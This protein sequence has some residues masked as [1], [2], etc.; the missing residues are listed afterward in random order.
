MIS[1]RCDIALGF[2][3]MIARVTGLL[4]FRTGGQKYII[5]GGGRRGRDNMTYGFVIL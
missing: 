4:V 5:R 1:V 2:G 3:L